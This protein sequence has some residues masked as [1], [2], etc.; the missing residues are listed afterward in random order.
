MIRPVRSEVEG[1]DV[2]PEGVSGGLRV[3]NVV[4]GVDEGAFVLLG[5]TAFAEADSL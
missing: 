4:P 3:E 5:E 2:I 1:L